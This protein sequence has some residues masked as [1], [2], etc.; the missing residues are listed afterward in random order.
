LQALYFTDGFR[1]ALAHH[2]SLIRRRKL[3]F[4][5]SGADDRQ[6]QQSLKAV[7]HFES[8]VSMLASLCDLFAK[9]ETQE[10]RNGV[11]APRNFIASVREQNALFRG[12]Q[13]QDAHEFLIWLLND[14]GESLERLNRQ[15]TTARR[16][17]RGTFV[18]E[19]FEGLLIHETKC[20]CCE[21][22]TARD[23]TF[24]NLSVDVEQHSSLSY[25]LRQFSSTELLAR[26]NKFFC[27]ACGGLQ[28]A[29]KRT[30]L[31]QLPPTLIVHLKRFKYV[32]QLERHCK[33]SHRVVFPFELRLDAVASGSTL[34]ELYAIVVHVGRGPNSGHY[35]ALIKSHGTWFV[36]DDHK[37]DTIEEN[38]IQACYG[39]CRPTNASSSSSSSSSN[40]SSSV[41]YLLFYQSS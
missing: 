32:E 34:Y 39:S 41:G 16:R 22:V 23:E 18:H 24:L 5:A 17:E 20:L 36:F 6:R 31:K 19:Q 2:K 15:T 25:C 10:R 11:V 29:Q 26:H 27:D 12:T 38:R 9:I 8:D 21:T 28:E 35:I 37:V 30:R 1:R 13:H 7:R 40:D 4:A 33:L 3:Q 14:I